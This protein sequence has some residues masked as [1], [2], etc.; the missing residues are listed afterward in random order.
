MHSMKIGRLAER[1]G[2]NI[3]TIRYY[4][5]NGF[6]PPPSRRPSGYRQYAETDVGRLRFIRRA[7]KLGFTLDQIAELLSLSARRDARG[8]KRRAQRRLTVVE[9]KIRELRRIRRGL[10]FL[11]AAGPGRGALEPCPIIAALSEE[12]HDD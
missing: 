7:K 9:Q 8:V 4:E 3:D 5:R 10:T 6:L 1:A 2:V 11:I 12:T